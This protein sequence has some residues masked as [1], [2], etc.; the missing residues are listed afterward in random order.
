MKPE[1]SSTDRSLVKWQGPKS[2]TPQDPGNAI[3]WPDT[4]RIDT[5]ERPHTD[6]AHTMM[7]DRYA[8]ISG[9]N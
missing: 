4:E 1:T 3:Y 9:A 7:A 5:Q 6:I 8:N 2:H